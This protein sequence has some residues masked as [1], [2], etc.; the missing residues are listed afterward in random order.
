MNDVQAIT[1]PFEIQF[2]RLGWT[3][4]INPTAFTIFGIDIQWYGLIITFGLVLA[5]IYVMPKMKRFGLDGEKALDA[6]IG[7]T[8]GGIVGA[9]AY[10][11]ILNW[12]YYKG[13]FK[14]IINTRNGGLAIY[15]GIIG[16]VIVGLL[17]CKMRKIKFLPMLD[18]TLLGFLIGQ[19][20]GRW[21]NFVNQEAFGTNTNNIFGMTGGTIQDTIFRNTTYADGSMLNIDID[22]LQP[23]HP[24]FLYESAWCLLGFLLISTYSK[25]RKYDG[26]I[27]LM[28]MTW[29]G[30]ERFVVEGL[31]TDSLM[32]GNIRF[33]QMLSLVICIA[34][35]I[36]QI[37]M[38][39]AVKRDPEKYVLYCNTE[40][41]KNMLEESRRLRH[42]D[43]DE[44]YDA[45]IDNNG[46]ESTPQENIQE[47]N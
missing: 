17:I 13:D 2:P 30:A 3:F 35:V 25:R 28:Y 26:Q 16:A 5:L 22:Y 38:Y 14:A 21:G 40:E 47:E 33:S 19:G 39:L 43:D 45:I 44:N 37:M 20:I 42:G 32:A 23:V 36:I 10:Y 12:D 9:R 15:G 4:H 18:I 11:V 7:G 34:S 46:D 24:C 41:S 31:R 27:L 8:I 1:D 6:I 29:Y